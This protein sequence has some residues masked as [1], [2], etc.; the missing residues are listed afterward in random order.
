MLHI[1]VMITAHP[2]SSGSEPLPCAGSNSAPTVSEVCD[3]ETLW[4]WPWLQK[5]LDVLSSV[6][7]FIKQQLIFSSSLPIIIINSSLKIKQGCWNYLI[8]IALLQAFTYDHLENN[9]IGI[10]LIN[11]LFYTQG[12]IL[13]ALVWYYLGSQ[14]SYWYDRL[15]GLFLKD[16]ITKQKIIFLM[17]FMLF[18]KTVLPLS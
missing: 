3:E 15:W 14:S 18:L 12:F 7:H 2:H 11:P 9:S 8:N 10:V 1:T 17:R 16:N 4:Q 13:K 6:N 5:R